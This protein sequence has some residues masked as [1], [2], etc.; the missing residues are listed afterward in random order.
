MTLFSCDTF[1]FYVAWVYIQY[2]VQ[3]LTRQFPGDASSP[4]EQGA[5]VGIILALLMV[6]TA[7]GFQVLSRAPLFH[8]HVRRFLEDYGMPIS[9]V[10]ASAMAY[11]GRFNFANPTTLPVGRAFLPAADRPW[12][13]KF[14]ELE[15]RWVGIALPFG[16]VLWI[17]FFFD[18]NVSV[19]NSFGSLR[20]FADYYS[21]R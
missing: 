4:E 7:F 18:H 21:S 6:F 10:A 11:W 15:G 13:V 12:L 3:V 17:L 2:G 9:L 14:W 1:G 16:F 5:L 8:K 20:S 19:S